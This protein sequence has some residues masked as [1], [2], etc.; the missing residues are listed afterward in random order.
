MSY[1]GDSLGKLARMEYEMLYVQ[2][3]NS[4]DFD[5]V[6]G[7]ELFV[8]YDEI[9]PDLYVCIDVNGR[10]VRSINYDIYAQRLKSVMIKYPNGVSEVYGIKK[11]VEKERYDELYSLSWE[12]PIIELEINGL[13]IEVSIVDLLEQGIKI[14]INDYNFDKE[15]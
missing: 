4:V 11:I 7:K 15:F 8:L 6:K 12:E 2:F 10:F 1:G 13:G 14:Y 3:C 9:L 5:D